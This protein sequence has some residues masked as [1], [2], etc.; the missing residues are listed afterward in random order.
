V[1]GAAVLRR[2]AT[3]EGDV[4]LLDSE[5]SREP[6][7]AIMGTVSRGY[8]TQVEAG[9]RTFSLVIGLGIWL[10][11]MLGGLIATA[12]D[13]VGVRRAGDT[14]VAEPGMTLLTAFVLWICAPFAA[15]WA[16]STVVGIPIGVGLF[17][18]ILPALGFLGYLVCGARLG[19]AA[20]RRIRAADAPERPFL[21]AAT[22]L[23]LLPLLGM[24]PF[25]GPLATLLAVT[26]GAG[27]VVLAAW[28]GSRLA[29]APVRPVP[30]EPR[31]LAELVEPA[32]V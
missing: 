18:F 8:W 2:G 30:P 9:L 11:V 20:L 16:M 26:S 14:L 32:P 6:G 12:V 31:V 24:V 1:R 28:R 7:A 29:A 27:A 4:Q 21:A 5:M 3:V 10:A 13:P 15:L 22:G 19:E 17:V 25:F 23:V